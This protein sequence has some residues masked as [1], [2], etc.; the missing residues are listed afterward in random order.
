[1]FRLS[2]CD[3]ECEGGDWNLA[4]GF[5]LFATVVYGARVRVVVWSKGVWSIG[6]LRACLVGK[7][8]R[9]KSSKDKEKAI[10]LK[11]LGVRKCR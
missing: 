9:R 3:A 1:M 10:N 11:H 2:P 5:R 4:F 6:A 7:T 8:T